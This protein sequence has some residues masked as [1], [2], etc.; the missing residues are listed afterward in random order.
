MSKNKYM[1]QLRT[2]DNVVNPEYDS[3]DP[4]NCI[5]T[6]SYFYNWIFANKGFGLPKNASILMYSEAKSGKSL[7]I[8]AHILE[9]QREDLAA[10]LAPDERRICFVFNS[11]LR[12]QLQF[13]VFQE[14]DMDY[15]III[16]S[17]NPT[18][19]F[20]YVD[21]D[22]R[23]MAQDGMKIGLIAIDSLT[24][25][26]GVK[27]QNAE[28]IENHLVGDHALTIGIGLSK[29]VPFCKRNKIPLICTS[30]IRGN[31]DAV[32]KYAPKEKMAES[33]AAKHAFEY[34]ISFKRAGAAEDKADIEGKTFTDDEM[35]DARGNELV[36]GHKIYAKMEASSIGQAGR[37][38]VF[39]ID[40]KR[41]I[42]NTHEE[43]FWL[44]YNLGV[45]KREGTKN[46]MIGDKKF[47][48]KAACAL[49]IK[50]DKE[51]A[52]VVLEGIQKLDEKAA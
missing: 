13:N 51:L 43:L 29:L 33:F 35:K 6:T 46:Y 2:A 49:A 15:V 19:I 3:Y 14:I 50:E 47:N 48:G 1:K 31:V 38:G 25:I 26:Q 4:S 41:G 5:R 8:Y 36:Y 45:I 11:E 20:D 16:D 23:A 52:K 39:F 7:M 32:N 18:E 30:Q 22:L 34:F 9:I 12:G 10:G 44:G 27:R 24:A 42:T 17:N 37:S 28:S 40:Y 21:K